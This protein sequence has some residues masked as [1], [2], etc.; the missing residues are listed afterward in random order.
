[1][2]GVQTRSPGAEIVARSHGSA[3]IPSLSPAQTATAKPKRGWFRRLLPLIVLLAAAVLGEYAYHWW[4]VGRFEETTD[5]AFLQ[6]DKVVVAPRIA[7]VI[8]SVEVADNQSVKAGDVLARIDDRDYQIALTMAQADQAKARA[9]LLSVA[10]AIIQQGAQIDSA[11]A[12]VTGAVAALK[13]SELEAIRYRTLLQTRAGTL[14]R[15]EQTDMDLQQKQ[16]ALAKAR[17]TLDGAT[18]QVDSLKA[19]EASMAASLQGAVAKVEQAKL[20][21]SYTTITAPV[22]GEVGD[23]SLR[24]GQVVAAGSNMLTIVPMLQDIYLLANFKETQI[25]DIAIGQKVD[26]TVDAFGS[27]AFHGRVAS[28]SP[29]T[30][31]QF[32]LLP[33]ENATGNFT[34]I[35]QRVPLKITLDGGDPMLAKLRPGL[36]A[37]AAVW[38]KNETT[39]TPA[40]Q[41]P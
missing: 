6:S 38:I 2:D 31:S 18:R 10:A 22:S 15:Q 7:G 21:L 40:V 9:T 1:M 19:L 25:G 13:F 12:D 32:A 4:T 39:T 11:R 27:H 37:D 24:T 28:F 14:Q 30:G 33:P 41:R 8:A 26:V 35:A 29:G 20:N 17:A 16:A 3:G 5:D 36:S 23:R 34:K